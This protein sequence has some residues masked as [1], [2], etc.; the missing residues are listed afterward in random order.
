MTHKL[1]FIERNQQQMF[2]WQIAEVEG[3][4]IIRAGR[5]TEFSP[6]GWETYDI[7]DN[8]VN[9]IEVVTN[10]VIDITDEEYTEFIEH[11]RLSRNII[12]RLNTATGATPDE[13]LYREG[14]YAIA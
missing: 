12:S 8:I 1:R 6:Y 3:K 7:P 13:R 2:L 4:S 11:T 14:A 10:I 9:T 5:H